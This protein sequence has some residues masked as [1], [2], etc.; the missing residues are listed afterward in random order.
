[1]LG[2]SI[3]GGGVGDDGFVVNGICDCTKVVLIWFLTL[4]KGDGAEVMVSTIIGCDQVYLY[5][6]Y[7]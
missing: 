7:L 1:M 4:L 2:G 5:E 6:D 3:V